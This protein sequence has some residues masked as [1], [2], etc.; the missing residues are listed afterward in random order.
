MIQV[1][2][3]NNN[4]LI[5]VNGI[6]YGVARKYTDLLKLLREVRC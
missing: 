4:Y 3:K 2:F 1:I 6:L 5:F